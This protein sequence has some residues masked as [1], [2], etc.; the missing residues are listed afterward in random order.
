MSVRN[1]TAQVQ[2]FGKSIA[3]MAITLE[4]LSEPRET[5]YLPERCHLVDC[6]VSQGILQ[7]R[8]LPLYHVVFRGLDIGRNLRKM[9]TERVGFKASHE[10][11]T[12]TVSLNCRLLLLP[13]WLHD[14]NFSWTKEA[15][16]SR[17]TSI[18]IDV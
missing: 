7:W 9:Y 16:N 3:L 15:V 2:K 8:L 12:N 14:H 1:G 17:S 11:Y 18:L 4:Q 6:L 13:Y 10:Y 5:M